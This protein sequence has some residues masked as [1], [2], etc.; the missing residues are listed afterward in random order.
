MFAKLTLNAVRIQSFI[1]VFCYTF[2]VLIGTKFLDGE[3]H[4][5]DAADSGE[6]DVLKQI[7]FMTL[8][9]IAG[10]VSFYKNPVIRTVA[11]HHQ[12]I[13]LMFLYA[14]VSIAWSYVP[15]IS[16]KRLVLTVL[17][18]LV[19]VLLVRAYSWKM[20]LD[21]L[22]LSLLVII[23]ISAITCLFH[24][25][26]VHTYDTL[27]EQLVG[28]WKGLFSHKNR[29]GAVAAITS[30]LSII[31]YI[32]SRKFV[33]LIAF[34]LSS[35]FLALTMSK[36]SISV[37]G[38][39]IIF[40]LLLVRY[41]LK[42]NTKL[43][44]A[45]FLSFA[46][47]LYLATIGITEIIESP[48]SISGRAAIWQVIFQVIEDNLFFGVGYASVYHVGV[49]SVLFDYAGDWIGLVAHGH[50]GFL[51][52]ALHLG[53][54]GLVLFLLLL[55]YPYFKLVYQSYLRAR[56]EEDRLLS[57][58]ALFVGIFFLLHN[59]TESSFFDTTRHGWFFFSFFY[60]ILIRTQEK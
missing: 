29:A 14:L 56:S 22:Y 55:L 1:L 23:A 15:M 13:A 33:F 43:V 38:P 60:A 52:L 34:F 45:L 27:D 17:V 49:D 30:G 48:D 7:L 39:A 26:A 47:F 41:R 4:I 31:Y 44:F 16:F 12:L 35:A 3:G 21:A 54:V 32:S 2:I 18:F 24:P 51:D 46:P 9:F 58:I 8:F 37:L 19:P 25:L 11:I 42:F 10:V 36:S 57:T 50:N 53:L 20:L 6:S 28:N 5:L 59:L 40:S